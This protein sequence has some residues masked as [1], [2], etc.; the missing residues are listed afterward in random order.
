MK[1]VDPLPVQIGQR[2][3]VLEQGQR[4]CLELPH[5]GSRGR[6]SIDSSAADNLTLDR[7]EG[8]PIGVFDILASGQ[9]PEHRLP[10][11]SVNTMNRVLPASS[12]VQCCCREIGQPECIIKLA[13]HKQAAARTDLR[14]PELHPHTA[15]ELYPICPLRARTLWVLHETRRS[16]PTIS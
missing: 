12:V 9:S 10:K 14:A 3:P 15:V 16:Q 2:R 4:L 5:L 13:H 6:L 1:P 7:I 11:Q 8:Q